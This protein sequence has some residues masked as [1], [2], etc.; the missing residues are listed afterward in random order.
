MKFTVF[1]DVAL[2]NLLQVYALLKLIFAFNIRA[3]SK[4]LDLF[5]VLMM[6]AAAALKT[7]V[8]FYKMTQRNIPE[9]SQLH[10]YYGYKRVSK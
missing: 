4:T 7:S 5:I 9:D 10:L 1:W 6:E 3:M 8:N 2:Y